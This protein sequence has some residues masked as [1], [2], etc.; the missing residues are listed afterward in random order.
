MEFVDVEEVVSAVI[1]EQDRSQRNA[2][3]PFS[4]VEFGR[5]FQLHELGRLHLFGEHRRRRRMPERGE[6]FVLQKEAPMSSHVLFPRPFRAKTLVFIELHAISLSFPLDHLVLRT[7]FHKSFTKCPHR[8]APAYK[9]SCPHPADRSP[10]FRRRD[11][12]GITL[13]E[14]QY[15]TPQVHRVE[16]R[17]EL[18]GE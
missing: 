1:A 4:R 10:D 11:T 7:I 2:P 5:S 9:S 13:R 3:L 12:R 18:V 16:P 15:S 6:S 14:V 8:K 17:Q